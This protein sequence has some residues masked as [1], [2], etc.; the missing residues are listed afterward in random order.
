MTRK[1]AGWRAADQLR[2]A[3][4]MS[5]SG[6]CPGRSAGSAP[7]P[8][9]PRKPGASP[10]AWDWETTPPHG[11]AAGCGATGLGRPGSATSGGSS[12]AQAASGR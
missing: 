4:C 11:K 10:A 2:T 8:R 7:L 9:P 1:A 5:V 12:E 6:T 3:S